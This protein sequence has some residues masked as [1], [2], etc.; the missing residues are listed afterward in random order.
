MATS[1]LAN[2]CVRGSRRCWW[3]SCARSARNDSSGV[4]STASMPASTAQE[5]AV[6]VRKS[7]E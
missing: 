2:R 3:L 7:G 1:P 5:P 6:G 4:D